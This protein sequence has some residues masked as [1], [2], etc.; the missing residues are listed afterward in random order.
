MVLDTVPTVAT[1][2]MASATTDTC[3]HQTLAYSLGEIIQKG[4]LGLGSQGVEIH[5]VDY[6]IHVESVCRIAEPG[7]THGE[8]DL[9]V[10]I[11]DSMLLEVCLDCADG[12]DQLGL[13]N[14]S[15]CSSGSPWC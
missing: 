2:D 13:P 9:L 7:H 15:V 10:N 12:R 11:S 3:R 14:N 5:A 6:Q 1:T 4:T 8:S